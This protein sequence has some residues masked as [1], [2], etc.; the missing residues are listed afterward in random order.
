MVDIVGLEAVLARCKRKQVAER[1]DDVLVG[2][3]ENV[4]LRGEV[5]LLVDLVTA[6]ASQVVALRIEEQALEKAAGSVDGGRL[7]RAQTTIDLD[8]SVLTGESGVAVD[9]ALDDVGLTEQ[10]VDLVVG[11]GDAECTEEHGGGLLALAVD[12][13]HELVALIDLELEPCTTCRD[14]LSLV[15]LL[16]RV[17]L[18]GEVDTRRTDELRDDDALGTVDDEGALLGH[19]GEIAHEDELLFDLARLF[20]GETHVGQKRRLIGHILLAALLDV[21]R[22]VAELM[23]AEA[24][25]ENM[26]LAL[27]G[28]GLL[29][30]LA[31]TLVLKALKGIPLNGDEVG[32]LHS[33]RNLSEVDALALCGGERRSFSHQVFLLLEKGGC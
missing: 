16:A 21:V 31:E 9:G 2:K 29:E 7:A 13:D 24:D 22:G 11:D 20:V 4:L 17:H 10:L 18:R 19:H 26:V 23:L 28:T 3:D 1:G 25:L 5:E 30:R 14:D 33:L 27:D 6:D 32:E 8:E 15:D 12:G